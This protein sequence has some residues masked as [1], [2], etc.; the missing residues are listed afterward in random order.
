MLHPKTLKMT[1]DYEEMGL[2]IPGCK[3]FTPTETAGHVVMC[4]PQARNSE[5]LRKIERRR[6]AMATGWAVENS[7]IYRYGCDAVFPLSDHA[8]FTD[9]LRMVDLVQPKSVYTVHGYA[10]EFAQTLRR[11][12]VEAW[13]LGADNQLELSL[14]RAVR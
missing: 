4:P 8:D 1:R 3:A 5:W 6:T 9:L 13:A 12:G 7:A 10:R 2:A 14:H 11:R